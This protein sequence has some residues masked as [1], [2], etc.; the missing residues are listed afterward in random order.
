[1]SP[2]AEPLADDGRLAL[3]APATP[4][5]YAIDEPEPPPATETTLGYTPGRVLRAVRRRWYA[6]IPAGLLMAVVLGYAANELIASNYT[7]RTQ[8]SIAISQPGILSDGG[9]GDLSNYQRR[10]TA[11]VKSRHVLQAALNRPGV[12]E[13]AA[14]RNNPDPV[15]WLETSL[16]ADFSTSPDILKVTL[17]GPDPAELVILLDAV[18][19]AYLE[20]GVNRDAT[21]KKAALDRVHGLIEDD[22]VKLDAAR[23]AVT[24]K[25]E[26]FRSPDALA[27]RQRHMANVTHLANLR[28]Q[29]F[30]LDGTIQGWEQTRADLIAHPPAKDAVAAP[31]AADLAAATKLAIEADPAAQGVR[32]EVGKLQKE[33]DKVV[34][35]AAKGK[36]DPKAVDKKRELDEAKERLATRAAAVREETVRK[37]AADSNRDYEFRLREHTARLAD[38]KVQIDRTKGQ[39]AAVAAAVEKL[40]AATLAEA[41]GIAELD[42]LAARV[43][44]VDDRLKA[45][46]TRAEAIEIE[47]KAPSRA[48]THETAVV[49]Q[50][51]NPSKKLKLVAGAIAAGFLAGLLGVAFLDLRGG[52]I[53]SPEG[54]DR[55]LHTGVVG[56]IPRLSPGA[57]ATLARSPNG[58]SGSAAI[59]A[60]DAADACRTLLLNALG[61]GPKVI[62]VTSAGAGEGKTALTAQLALSLGRAG[63]RTL[64]IDGDIR[65]PGAHTLFGE[66]LGPGLTDVLRKTH[67]LPNVVRP[68]PLS[69][70]CVVPAGVCNPQE[71]VSLLQLRLGSLIRKCRPHFDV[72]LIDTPPLLNLPDAMIIGRHADG[73]ILSLMNEVSTLPDTQTACA[74]LRTLN[75]PLLG[76][77]LNGTRVKAPLGY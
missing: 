68:G 34:A 51:P 71:A 65:K 28:T 58:P 73:T 10:Q 33:F 36:D 20:H 64:V 23:L 74:R 46:K 32:A 54:V 59:A 53:D 8:V 70:V 30:Q 72:I 45:A 43:T 75:L 12:S 56:C 62:M 52:R 16:K 48:Q 49:T 47:L 42:R 50:V 39:M 19:E 2:R 9:V 60:C 21:E 41:R 3:A 69:A 31:S 4:V 1:M 24:K 22:K 25:A 13:L 6:A 38:L 17:S 44:E 5:P 77:V 37:L 61:T 14:V 57:L 7:V 66:A 15:G 29:L 26:E 35:L 67:S 11:L 55:H 76:A 18:R 27:A 40:D 63:K